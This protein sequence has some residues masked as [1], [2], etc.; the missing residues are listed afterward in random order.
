MAVEAT[1]V[2]VPHFLNTAR[3]A[4]TFA[5]PNLL[6]RCASPA[7]RASRKVRYAPIVDPIVATAAYSYHGLRRVETRIARRISGPPK[8][9]T[10]ELSRIVRKKSPNAPR[11]RNI[12]R[13]ERPRF[14]FWSRIF[15]IDQRDDR[16]V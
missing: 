16:A 8:V 5:C 9:G 12:E 10:G 13:H 2:P 4:E 6:S 7:F 1:K 15:K 11:W 14:A 3:N